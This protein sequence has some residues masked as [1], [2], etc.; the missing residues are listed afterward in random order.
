M[1]MKENLLRSRRAWLRSCAKRHNKTKIGE[2]MPEVQFDEVKRKLNEIF[3]QVFDDGSIQINDDMTAKNIEG[4]DSL[5]HV[6]LIVGVEKRFKIAFSTKEVMS[7]RNVGD[8]LR[9]IEKK[10]SR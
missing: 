9:L 5:T 2:T 8:F 7:L 3:Q 1:R 10:I 4:W 6:N